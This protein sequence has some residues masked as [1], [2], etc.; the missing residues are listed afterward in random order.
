MF[1]GIKCLWIKISLSSKGYIIVWSNKYITLFWTLKD[2][3]IEGLNLPKL[4]NVAAK[5]Y[6][7][8]WKWRRW[9]GKREKI[10]SE[11]VSEA[12]K[13]FSRKQKK[14]YTY[15]KCNDENV[16]YEHKET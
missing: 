3:D 9:E 10:E 7:L 13:E 16:D 1:Y 8:W 5:D 11:K 4:W 12:L 6:I 14:A 2:K 15:I